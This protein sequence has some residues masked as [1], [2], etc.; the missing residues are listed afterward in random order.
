M[1][2]GQFFSDLE[3]Q[4]TA[5][6]DSGSR[7]SSRLAPAAVAALAVAAMSVVTVSYLGASRDP[8]PAVLDQG[9]DVDRMGWVQAIET[10]PEVFVSTIAVADSFYVVSQTASGSAIYE[11]SSEPTDS[12]TTTIRGFT[13]NSIAAADGVFVLAG[14][15]NGNGLLWSSDLTKWD[16]VEMVGTTSVDTVTLVAASQGNFAALGYTDDEASPVILGSDNGREWISHT[17]PFGAS[18]A[19]IHTSEDRTWIAGADS[20][21]P[22][23][24]TAGLGEDWIRSVLPLPP[25][26]SGGAV[27]ALA[28]DDSALVAVGFVEHGSFRYPAAWLQTGD[29]WRWVWV[30]PQESAIP[31]VGIGSLAKGPEGFVAAGTADWG[32]VSIP[33]VVTST[34]GLKWSEPAVIEDRAAWSSRSTSVA[35]SRTGGWAISGFVDRLD[36]PVGILWVAT[37]DRSAGG[38][39][40]DSSVPAITSDTAKAMP[41]WSITV[42]IVDPP[43]SDN[44]VIYL[45]SVGRA[46]VE[47]CRI[48]S[49]DN[50]DACTGPVPDV[51]PGLYSLS[52]EPIPSGFSG[53]DVEVV[54]TPE[55][56]VEMRVLYSPTVGPNVLSLSLST[57]STSNVPI[58]NWTVE[59]QRSGEAYIVPHGTGVRRGSGFTLDFSG[60]GGR[61]CPEQL[62][63]FVHWCTVR[64]ET[65]VSPSRADQLWSGGELVLRDPDGS[66]VSSWTPRP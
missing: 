8:G 31:L 43:S 51:E 37:S 56:S 54:R 1:S 23:V 55:E 40:L 64:G 15:G 53:W 26:T 17:T 14:S 58:G 10:G 42:N 49:S 52:F 41:G 27:T 19:A 46:G 3:H 35:A 28:G 44:S 61:R 63:R 38:P 33:F 60:P 32:P 18:V 30:R 21:Q 7:R 59:D 45:T 39:L 57:G 5:S 24:W 13:G 25:N 34:D 62:P 20:T 50:R 16:S 4:L 9:V 66:L 36:N 48:S 47:L 29:S 12:P 65:R 22:T 6:M 2:R 11:F